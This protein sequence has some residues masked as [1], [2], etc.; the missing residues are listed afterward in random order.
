M[1]GSK[2]SMKPNS[3]SER[4]KPAKATTNR[5]DQSLNHPKRGRPQDK[6]Q[7][8]FT[9]PDS[10]IMKNSTNQGVDQHYN[11]QAAA[12]QASMFIIATRLSNHPNDKREA[13]PTLNAISPEIGK[14]KAAALDNGYFSAANIQGC[15]LC[16]K[17]NPTSL[18]VVNRII[19]IGIPSS[20]SNQNRPTRMPVPRSRWLTS[21]RVILVRPSTA[22]A[23]VR[24]NPSL[25]SSRRSWASDNSL[26]AAW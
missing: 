23:S 22:C 15:E 20:K 21:C 10:R 16:W 12:D 14:P 19:K 3:G 8:N 7:Y 11:V 18:P 9:D 24:S 1:R 4:R 6:D 26:C 2:P 13:L 5:A 25:G 17:L